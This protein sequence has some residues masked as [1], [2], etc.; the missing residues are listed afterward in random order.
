MNHSII[1]ADDDLNILTALKLLLKPLSYK[2]TLVSSPN[3][4]IEHLRQREYT[5]ALLDLNYT[6]DT[7]SGDE[8][9]SLITQVKQLDNA[10]PIIA[11]TGFAS[12]EI[13]V[14]VM[15]TGCVDF[16]QKPWDDERLLTTIRLQCQLRDTVRR[17]QRLECQNNLLKKEVFSDVSGIQIKSEVMKTCIAQLKRLALSDMN[18]LLTGE[19]G[20]GKSALANYVHQCSMR[21]DNSFVAV[22]MGAIS[23]NLFESELFGHTKGAFT[24]AKSDRIGRFELAEGGTLFLDEIANIP[25]SQQAKLLHVLEARKYEKLGNSKT[26]DANV[27]LISA[28]NGNLVE[29]IQQGRFREDLF[30]RINTV[31][32]RIPPLRKR[33]EDIIPMAEAFTVQ[34]ATKY[35]M[36]I[37]NLMDCAK[38]LLT[39]YA[40]PGN[41]RELKH[42]IERAMFLKRGNNITAGDLGLLDATFSHSSIDFTVATLE[43]IDRFLIKQRLELYDNKVAETIQSLGLSRSAYY[44]RVEKYKIT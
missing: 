23:E 20:T 4:L 2:V 40:W 36:P 5:M 44:R 15:K 38:T 33:V 13:A 30:Y 35:M 41:V 1:I 34:F 27:R 32:V 10:M 28:T 9:V 22:N 19:N 14:D 21:A 37:P 18:I 17:N 39:G 43:D 26:T 6:K 31:E 12:V 16:I 8:G 42:M 24:D 25:L 3:A 29:L 7:T 11:M